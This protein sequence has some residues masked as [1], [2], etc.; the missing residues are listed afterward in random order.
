MRVCVKGGNSFFYCVG[1][2]R[3]TYDLTENLKAR[4]RRGKKLFEHDDEEEV[5]IKRFK[6][7][8][9]IIWFVNTI[10]AIALGPD[11]WN[12]QVLS[13]MLNIYLF[14]FSISS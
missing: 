4:R 8:F 10:T 12:Q 3:E 6:V 9:D 2:V 11:S 13:S 5:E 1:V 14:N 7:I